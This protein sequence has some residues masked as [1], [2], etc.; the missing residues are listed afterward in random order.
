MDDEKVTYLNTAELPVERILGST[1]AHAC[2][3]VIV[4]GWDKDKFFFATS[5][6]DTA[7]INLSLDM[8]KRH[9][10]DIVLYG[11]E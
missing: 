9:T 7:D 11:D 3:R 1:E 2:D 4:I 6:G 8:A 10:L 5:T